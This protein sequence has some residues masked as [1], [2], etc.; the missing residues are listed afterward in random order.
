[1]GKLVLTCD[2]NPAGSAALGTEG[3]QNLAIEFLAPSKNTPINIYNLG[4]DGILKY[5]GG[6]AIYQAGTFEIIYGYADSTPVTY[7]DVSVANGGYSILGEKDIIGWRFRSSVQAST[8]VQYVASTAYSG[9]YTMFQLY[10]VQLG[11]NSRATGLSAQVRLYIL[12]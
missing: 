5:P 4:V 3:E 12:G 8:S 7:L 11:S 1:M 6:G 9:S 10:Q 2:A